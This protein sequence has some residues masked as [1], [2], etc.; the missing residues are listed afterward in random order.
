MDKVNWKDI[1]YKVMV[2][3]IL[4]VCINL[5]MQSRPMYEFET[6]YYIGNIASTSILYLIV[7]LGKESVRHRL[8][9]ENQMKSRLSKLGIDKKEVIFHGIVIIIFVTISLFLEGM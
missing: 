5:Y 1:G 3:V 4:Y 6:W 8:N 7:F 2:Y 9:D